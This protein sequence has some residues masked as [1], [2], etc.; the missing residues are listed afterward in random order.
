MPTGTATTYGLT[1][2]TKLNVEDFIY[3]LT[4]TDVPLLGTYNGFDNVPPGKN[5]SILGREDVDEIKVEWQEEELIPARS[6]L[7]TSIADSTATAVVVATGHGIRFQKGHVIK[8]EDEFMR[9]SSVATDTLTVT[10]A[11]AGTAVAH[12]VTG[13]T[14]QVVGVGTALAEGSDPEAARTK[15][16]VMSHNFTEIFGPYAITL[17]GTENVVAK[18]GVTNEFDKQSANRLKEMMIEI[19]QM[20]MY[21]VRVND[22]SNSWRTAGGFTFYVT[23]NVDSSTTALTETTLLAQ[24]Q[25]S[26]DNGGVPDLIV[27]NPTQKRKISAFGSSGVRIAQADNVRGTVVDTYLSDFGTID[28]VMSRHVRLQNLFI[29]DKQ[30]WSLGTLR[31]LEI[32]A[33]AKTGDSIKAEVVCEKTSK[34]RLEKRHALFT[35]L[36]A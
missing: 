19:E 5:V 32:E 29:A 18:Y 4:P 25:A 31:P 12:T 33:L 36:A 28:V 26:Y 20:L 8:I 1:V 24:M 10:R 17:S 16:R 9:V 34:V 14:T 21:G 15:D 11:F 27:T 3:I 30:Y 35:A 22:T 6:T 2:G 13:A 23:T 7:A